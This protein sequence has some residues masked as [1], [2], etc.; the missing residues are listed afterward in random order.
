V[1][2]ELARLKKEFYYDGSSVFSWPSTGC[3][4]ADDRSEQPLEAVYEG[5][6]FALAC[7]QRIDIRKLTS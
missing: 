1:G 6:L 7:G 2:Y 4:R 5:E 3:E